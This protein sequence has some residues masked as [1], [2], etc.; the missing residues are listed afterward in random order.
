[1]TEKPKN[2][3]STE[4]A[5][6]MAEEEIQVVTYDEVHEVQAVAVDAEPFPSTQSQQQG[7]YESDV[8]VSGFPSSGGGPPQAYATQPNHASTSGVGLECTLCGDTRLHQISPGTSFSISLCGNTYVDVHD[9][10]FPPNAKITVISVRLCGN[11]TF[12]VPK[13]TRANVCRI[14]LCGNRNIHVEQEPEIDPLNPPPSLNINVIGLC[15]DI[16]VCSDPDEVN[17]GGQIRIPSFRK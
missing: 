14:T 7:A 9:V 2:E 4:S 10:N 1:M 11:I 17:G 6:G 15:G 3:P 12:I 8:P 16:R 5:T 13:N